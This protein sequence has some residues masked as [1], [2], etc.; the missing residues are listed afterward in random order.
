MTAQYH[1]SA[2]QTRL[3]KL[4]LEHDAFFF[5]VDGTLLDIASRPEDVVVPETLRNDLA[6]L[7]DRCGGAIALISGRKL[8]IINALFEPLKLATVGCHGAEMRLTPNGPREQFAPPVPEDVRRAF[9]DVGK[10]DPRIIVE[11][12]SYTL[13]FH[14]RAAMDRE[15]ELLALVQKKLAPFEPEFTMLHGKAIIE[16]KS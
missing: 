4:D 3:P 6:A 15:D 11:D 12:K 1:P 8:A 10:L 2:V 16:I 14:Y 13:A 7:R 9:A 5:D